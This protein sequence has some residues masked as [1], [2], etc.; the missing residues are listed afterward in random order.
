MHNIGDK[1]MY[2]AGGVMT[3]VDIREEAIGDVSRSYFVLR[4]SLARTD[5][6]TFVPMD[7]ERLVSFMHPLLSREEI[8]SLIRS[9]GDIAP[10]EWIAENRARQEHFKKVLESGD[11][12]QMIAMIHAINEHGRLRLAEGKK[13]FLSDENARLKA[14]R[15]LYSEISVV[16]DIPEDQV[17]AFV[18]GE[19]A[20]V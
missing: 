13:N 17:A 12:I 20:K 16:F 10:L 19:L 18:Q 5:S 1:I 11:R 8:H 6:F 4:P 2:G 3:V 7:N 14:E 15:L 9:S